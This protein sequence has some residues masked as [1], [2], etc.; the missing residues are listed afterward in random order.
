MEVPKPN[1]APKDIHVTT[2][3]SWVSSCTAR[4][5]HGLANANLLQEASARPAF[6]RQSKAASVLWDSGTIA[7]EATMMGD[8]T[9]SLTDSIG[10]P[11]VR[12]L[13]PNVFTDRNLHPAHEHRNR[14]WGCL[15]RW[16]WC[17]LDAA[18]A[19]KGG[20]H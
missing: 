19:A 7:D 16:P 5:A 4:T 10:R 8:N 3:L 13:R 18:L 15:R 11:K 2:R 17:N 12:G 1:P 6:A 20:H 9:I 14:G